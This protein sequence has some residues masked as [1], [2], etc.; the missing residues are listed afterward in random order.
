MA[1][2]PPSRRQLPVSLGSQH[3]L[4]QQFDKLSI[5]IGKAIA[6]RGLVYGGGSSGLMGIVSL[7]TLEAGGK[8]IGVVPAAMLAG[9][10]GWPQSGEGSKV[11]VETAPQTKEA[12][13]VVLKHGEPVILAEIGREKVRHIVQ[14]TACH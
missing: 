10:R 13:G 8:V 14:L 7:A 2:K 11:E 4:I 1:F 5:A 9:K 6:P 3:R 12:L